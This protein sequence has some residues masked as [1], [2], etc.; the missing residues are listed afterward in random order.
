MFGVG[1]KPHTHLSLS[2]LT[3]GCLTTLQE[4]GI[5]ILALPLPAVQC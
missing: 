4:I 2:D 5:L 3:P 1:G